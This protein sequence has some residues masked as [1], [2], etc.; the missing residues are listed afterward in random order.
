MF[1]KICK[2]WAIGVVIALIVGTAAGFVYAAIQSPIAIVTFVVGVVGYVV[3][4]IGME[5]L[6][7][8]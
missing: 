2:W 6:C 1:A 4:L 7:D 5:E 8:S 3:F